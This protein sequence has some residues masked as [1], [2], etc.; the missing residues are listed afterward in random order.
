MKPAKRKRMTG[1]PV[2]L[3]AFV[4]VA[5]FSGDIKVQTHVPVTAVAQ[6][7]MTAEPAAP[8]PAP[9]AVPVPPE[10]VADIRFRPPARTG[11][12]QY[13]IIA[14][15]TARTDLQQASIAIQTSPGTTCLNRPPQKRM[16]LDSGDTA[17]AV[18]RVSVPPG[19]PGTITVSLDSPTG[20]A[21]ASLHVP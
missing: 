7:Q 18:Y 17:S 20:T 12:N 5:V 19:E 14:E 16:S 21:E 9:P 3:A 15:V 10:P 8:A 2:I 4:L 6:N 1:I 13:A 11:P